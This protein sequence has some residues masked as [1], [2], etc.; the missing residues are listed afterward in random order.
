M[1]PTATVTA[2]SVP[3]VPPRQPSLTGILAIAV[4]WLPIC[5]FYGCHYTSCEEA[6]PGLSVPPMARPSDG[7]PHHSYRTIPTDQTL[8][9]YNH[10]SSIVALPDGSVLVA[11][12]AGSRELG[13]DTVIL[14]ACLRPGKGDWPHPQIWA[15]K[16]DFADAN[17]VLFLDDSGSLRL[18]HV[19]MFGDTFCLGN[20]VE[21][22]TVDQGTTW[23]KPSV[24]LGAT[25]VMVR[26]RPIITRTG[27]WILPAYVQGIY[28]AQFWL[29]DDRGHSW[30]AT[31]PLLTFPNNLQ[32]AVVELRDGAL[33]ALMR[34]DGNGSF[35]WQARSQDGGQTW[36]LCRRVGL[37]NPNS[38]LDLLRL[39]DDRLVL[40]YNDSE[41]ERYPLVV[42]LSADDGL[43]WSPPRIIHPGP[44]RAAYPSLTEG[45][46]GLI[47]LSYSHDLHHIEHVTINAAWILDQELRGDGNGS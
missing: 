14:G 41:R 33:F 23:S 3:R 19:E 11:W 28:Q 31:E 36:E 45:P 37:R 9:P 34:T 5:S 7:Q 43:T 10:A 35:T 39:A 42:C 12:G 29:S 8:Y 46:D 16:P 25:C 26:N 4:L 22:I 21:Q 20:V 15:D 18:F 44:V 13:E 38:G 27:R 17:P 40:A 6:F 32:P 30:I 1:T 47:H 24:T 2:R